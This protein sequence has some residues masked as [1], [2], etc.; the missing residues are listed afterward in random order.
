VTRFIEVGWRRQGSEISGGDK[1]SSYNVAIQTNGNKY[2]VLQ[3]CTV[4]F[5][6]NNIVVEDSICKTWLAMGSIHTKAHYPCICFQSA[7]FRPLHSSEISGRCS[8]SFLNAQHEIISSLL[9]ALHLTHGIIPM[10][11]TKAC[12]NGY[13]MANDF[14]HVNVQCSW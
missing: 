6:E 11:E 12:L 1:L 3:C 5:T 10:P 14:W 2:S 9:T 13:N 8:C 7:K 4:V